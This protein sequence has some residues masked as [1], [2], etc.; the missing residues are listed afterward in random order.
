MSMG[1]RMAGKV[2]VVVGAT[3]GMGR[4]TARLLAQEGASVAIAGRR[5]GLLQELGEEIAA[6]TG[7]AALGVPCDASDR[8]QVASLILLTRAQYGRIDLLV[9]ATGT[10][11]PD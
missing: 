6:E 3:S 1:G 7:R 2:A 11:I 4:A 5:S 8:E 10:N 9:Y